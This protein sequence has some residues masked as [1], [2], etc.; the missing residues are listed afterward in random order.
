MC[1]LQV[2][3]KTQTSS[4][5]SDGNSR[6]APTRICK[7]DGI[8]DAVL[9][10]NILKTTLVPFIGEKLPDHPLMQYNNAKHTSR[11]AKA[12]RKMEESTGGRLQL[13]VQT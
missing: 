4:Q 7:F 3:A 5:S 8:M 6:H 1:L 10:C 2:Q 12:E 9:F 13:K 11:Q